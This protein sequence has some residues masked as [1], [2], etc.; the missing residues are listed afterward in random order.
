MAFGQKLSCQ[1]ARDLARPKKRQRQLCNLFPERY[2]RSLPNANPPDRAV[3]V[4]T[5]QKATVFGHRNSDGPPPN[6]ALGRHETS[7][8]VLVFARRLSGRV[9]KQHAYDFVAGP[10]FS[11][12]RAVTGDEYVVL[13][14]GGKLGAGVKAKVQRS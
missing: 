3:G 5:K 2:I 4:F 8:K 9:I 14:L 11:V 1:P 13:V 7:Y 12:P 6:I 10:L